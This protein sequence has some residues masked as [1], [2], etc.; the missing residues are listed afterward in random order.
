MPG[1][2]ITPHDFALTP[3]YYLFF[4]N[5]FSLDILPY[6]LGKKAPADCLTLNPRATKV[7]LI[8][9]PSCDHANTAPYF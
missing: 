6:L 8:P 3:N 1:A 5:A 4:E 2:A 7:H 9:R